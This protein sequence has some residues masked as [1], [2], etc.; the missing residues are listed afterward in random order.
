[1]QQRN[2]SAISKS[3]LALFWPEF[4]LKSDG[5]HTSPNSITAESNIQVMRIKEVNVKLLIVRNSRGNY[6]GNVLENS[7]ENLHTDV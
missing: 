5:H 7:L 6:I 1:M 3:N 2:A 4:T